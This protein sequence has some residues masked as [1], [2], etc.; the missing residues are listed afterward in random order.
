VLTL[1]P[2]LEEIVHLAAAGREDDVVIL[3]PPEQQ[4]RADRAVLERVVGNLVTN[5][6]QYGAPP[7]RLTAEQTD[8][9]LRV[10]VSD[11]GEGIDPQFVPHLFDRFRR[12][13]DS[14]RRASG[15][16]LGLSIARAYAR[17]H[18]GDLL[19]HAPD[20]GGAEFEL[21]LPRTNPNAG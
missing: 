7:I 16:G 3:T 21:V 18:G 13:D 20:E 6:L 12:S 15:A 9:H 1:K 14:Q 5:A 19:Y 8:T 2:E 17:A 11:S 10:T 4:V